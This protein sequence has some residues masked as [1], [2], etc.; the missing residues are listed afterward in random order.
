M[1]VQ[2]ILTVVNIAIFIS[3]LSIS[4]IIIGF[5]NNPP[6]FTYLAVG[7]Y[8]LDY[9]EYLQQTAQGMMGHW[10]V[11]NQFATDDPT[12]TI[13]GWGQYLIIGKIAKFLHLSVVAG[14]WLGVFFLVFFCCLSI[15]FIIKRLLPNLSFFCQLAAWFF[16]LFAAP[17]VNNKLV[18]FDFWYAPMSFFHRFGGIPHHLSTVILTVVALIMSS[19]IFNLL[20]TESFKKLVWR[21]IILIGLLL[22]LLTFGPLQVINIISSIFLVGIIF[23]IRNK[24][25]KNLIY[26]GILIVIFIFPAALLIRIA[27]DGSSLFQRINVWEAS[28]ENHPELLSIVLTTG[29]VLFFAALGL[30]RYFKEISNIRLILF[31]YVLFSYVYYSTSLA[32]YFGTFNSRFLTASV[33]IL[34]GTLA[35]LGIIEI[36]NWFGKRKTILISSL[37]FLLLV[38]FFWVTAIIYK[39]FGPV[40]QTSY[41]P[42]SIYKAMQFLGD[43]P[44]KSAVLTSP[45]KY[46]GA[47]VP[48]FADKNVYIARP[49]FTPDFDNRLNISDKF[50]RGAMDPIE[51]K[52]FLKNNKIGFVFLTFMENYQPENLNEYP[53]LNKIYDKEG[54]R[55]FKVL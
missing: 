24:I 43:Q 11:L 44:D 8:Y 4:R 6:G 40:D 30:R 47:V 54:V 19:D 51:A 5:I 18:P 34:F 10:T 37:I 9:F 29:P 36:A 25:S 13:L 3:F 33:Y 14:Y 17:F 46:F 22:V 53:F 20:K 52:T 28:Q 1:K 2:K 27:H 16:C 55:I 48:V 35:I 50:F 45:D 23:S 31:S 32:R 26:F 21:I 41:L 38:Y 39:S 12:Q 42:N 15:Y 7:H 49:M